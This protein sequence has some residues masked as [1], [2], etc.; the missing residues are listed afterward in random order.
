MKARLLESGLDIFRRLLL[1][2]TILGYLLE[3]PSFASIG[4]IYC[5]WVRGLIRGIGIITYG[6]NLE[7]IR[8]FNS[9]IDFDSV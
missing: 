7:M 5:M 1:E 9:I 6:G 3:S 8:L 2:M 4:A